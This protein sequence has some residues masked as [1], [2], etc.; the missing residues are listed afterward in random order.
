[1]LHP[2]LRDHFS[3]FITTTM[4][5]AAITSPQP[6]GVFFPLSVLQNGNDF[7]CSDVP[8]N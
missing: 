6:Y 4:Q 2:S 3:H 8:P 1:M 5:S 7:T